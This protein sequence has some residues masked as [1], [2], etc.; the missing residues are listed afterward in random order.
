MSNESTPKEVVKTEEHENPQ[1]VNDAEN[2]KK[3][4]EGGDQNSEQTETK[5]PEGEPGYEKKEIPA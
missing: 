2:D 1:P 4:K 5:N 3:T